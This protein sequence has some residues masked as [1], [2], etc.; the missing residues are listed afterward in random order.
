MVDWTL[1]VE[2]LGRGP[3][4]IRPELC[5]R[6]RHRQAQCPACVSSC[7]QSA[8]YFQEEDSEVAGP[9]RL[10]P[11][12]VDPKRCLA[13]GTCMSVCPGG[14][15]ELQG[16][17]WCELY[18]AVKSL[19][20]QRQ[21]LAV[22]CQEAVRAAGSLAA[23]ACRRKQEIEPIP[24]LPEVLIIPCLALLTAPLLACAWRLR[25]Q[26]LEVYAGD[27]A[28]CPLAGG[29]DRVGGLKERYRH[30]SRLLSYWGES[31]PARWG[32]LEEL[33]PPI[34]AQIEGRG[35][36][37]EGRAPRVGGVSRRDFFKIFSRQ[38]ITTA[39][40][41]VLPET[42]VDPVFREPQVPWPRRI[43]LWGLGALDPARVN[44]G[45]AAEATAGEGQG[46]QAEGAGQEPRDQVEGALA[47][48]AASAH[49]EISRACT[50]CSICARVCPTG[51]LQISVPVAP[52]PV[53]L[54]PG[55]DVQVA[56]GESQDKPQ[57]GIPGVA[58]HDREA[59]ATPVGGAGE[60]GLA[61]RF[62]PA[63]CI[64]CGLC[65]AVCFTGALRRAGPAQV[66][67]LLGEEEKVLFQGFRR[68]CAL[69]GRDFIG[70]AQ[71]DYCPSCRSLWPEGQLG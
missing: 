36:G 14:A 16:Y 69:C 44:R 15:L 10:H 32:G 37:Q 50:G 28:G 62:K 70:Q 67:E 17:G 13:C 24:G 47:A 7:P 52:L 46:D 31:L 33:I 64:D 51:A 21:R 3:V 41:A 71:D 39:L 63:Y 48:V 42:T 53:G 68:Q 65:Q 12:E 40:D 4:V 61:I 59:G 34:Q 66:G 49:L 55:G 29:Q 58:S 54:P 26:Q 18:G 6:S 23:A 2:K 5:L 30:F 19:V 43:A 45:P 11:P 1:L 8:L 20:E 38:A 9:G 35:G 60:A 25:A 57:T 27:C 56:A 22:A